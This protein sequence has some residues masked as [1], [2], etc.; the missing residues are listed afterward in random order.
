MQRGGADAAGQ[1]APGEPVD[2]AVG[3]NEHDHAAV[4][5]RDVGDGGGLVAVRDVQQVVLHGR[6]GSG[7]RVH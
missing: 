5:G 6:H 3:V 7:R 4:P 1:Q 2:A